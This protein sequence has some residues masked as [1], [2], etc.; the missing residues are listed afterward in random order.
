MRKEKRIAIFEGEEIRR[1]W[2]EA[3]EKW[4]FSVVDAIGVLTGSVKPR[5]YWHAMKTRVKSEDGVEL[6]TICRQLKMI[7]FPDIEC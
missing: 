1:Y 4:W 6:S 3:E 5:V 2:D 7:N